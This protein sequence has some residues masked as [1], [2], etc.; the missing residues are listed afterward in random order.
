MDEIWIVYDLPRG[1]MYKAFISH[2]DA[3]AYIK[4]DPNLT[5]EQIT[6]QPDTARE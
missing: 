1:I 2:K 6:L 4:N 5:I 3:V